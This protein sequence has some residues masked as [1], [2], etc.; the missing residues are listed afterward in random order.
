MR[1]THS[2]K[3][4]DTE[5]A[6]GSDRRLRPRFSVPRCHVFSGG[7]RVHLLNLA[8][9]GMA[10]ESFGRCAFSRS[11][12]HR[13]VLDDGMNSIEVVGNVSWVASS[14]V[15][16]TQ[17]PG[18]GLV[19]TVGISFREVISPYRAGLWRNIESRVLPSSNTGQ[20][21]VSIAESPA[22]MV[23]PPATMDKPSDGSITSERFIAVEGYL[24]DPDATTT[25]TINGFRA[26]II[27][28]RF[29]ARVQLTGDVNYLCAV[30]THW[31]TSDSTCFLGKVI[32]ELTDE[33]PD[34]PTA[35][36]FQSQ[37]ALE[38]GADILVLPA[39][40]EN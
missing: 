20:D 10:I 32:R 14:W 1:T 7:K 24:R 39:L 36:T 9:A 16:D 30:L 31:N 21:L 35:K 18:T 17:V 26:T 34:G 4:I 5:E 6:S 22:A 38:G 25:M 37:D 33:T 2:L 13:F 27:G 29:S 3:Q 19:Q 28:G 11:E 12:N 8:R 40:P 15:D 23:R